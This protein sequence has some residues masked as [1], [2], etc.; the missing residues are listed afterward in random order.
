MLN[1]TGEMVRTGK[2]RLVRA[3]GRLVAAVV[4]TA[5]LAAGPA[6]TLYILHTNNTNG[7]LENCYCSEH[8]YGAVEKRAAFV[9]AW[10]QEHPNTV[11][12]DA[13]DFLSLTN[14]GI[15]DS[16]MCEAYR[17]IPYDVILPGDQE[18]NREP[19]EIA[20]LLPLTGAPLLG[21]NIVRPEVPG[22]VPYRIVERGGLRI[23]LLGYFGPA[24]IKYY[25]EEVREQFFL[26]EEGTASLEQRI[27]ELRD[28]VDIVILL[29]HQGYDYDLKIAA[30][31]TGVDVLVGAHSQTSLQTA[32]EI[33]GILVGQAG[34]EG[35][36]VGIVKV[37]FDEANRIVGKSGYL[38]PMTLE[39][40]DH[41]RVLELIGEYERRTGI[42]NHRKLEINARKNN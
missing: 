35:Y 38:V 13:G 19:V 31:L 8:P 11:I 29:T 1:F 42:V 27:A 36:H 17:T 32:Q 33:N 3:W 24:A 16:L 25:P 15:K 39:M 18:L 7:A 14:R 34:K 20:T 30:N 21:A 9:A 4:L 2:S 23:A 22:G 6:R 37:D 28:S 5:G 40:P 10:L 12:V 26:E 41:P